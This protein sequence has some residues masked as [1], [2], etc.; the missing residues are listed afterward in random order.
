MPSQQ[1][2]HDL[3]QTCPRDVIAYNLIPP[4]LILRPSSSL[5]RSSSLLLTPP[6]SSSLLRPFILTPRQKRGSNGLYISTT[7]TLR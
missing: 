1:V 6:H 4:H 5:L 2:S 3:F 7:I